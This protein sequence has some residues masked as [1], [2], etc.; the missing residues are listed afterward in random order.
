M[1]TLWGC[2]VIEQISLHIRLA[3]IAIFLQNVTSRFKKKNTVK[4]A[5]F[6]M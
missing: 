5:F 2:S 3:E 4:D 1:F 6:G